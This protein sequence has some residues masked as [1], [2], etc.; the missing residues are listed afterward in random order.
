[1][2]GELMVEEYKLHRQEISQ[3]VASVSHWQMIGFIAAGIAIAWALFSGGWII[4]AV[5]LVVIAGCIFGIIHDTTSILCIAAYIQI[6]HEGKDTGALW[7]T[8]LESIANAPVFTPYRPYMTP[9]VSLLWVGLLC[10]LIAGIVPTVVPAE[11]ERTDWTLIIPMVWLAFW[12]F[13]RPNYRAFGGPDGFKEQT[14]QAF[15]DALRQPSQDEP[16]P[17]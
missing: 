17:R 7:E 12:A 1:M 4:A 2:A 15:Y 8:R 10:A 13:I 6:F 16:K 5:A 14:R 3:H 11:L 9:V